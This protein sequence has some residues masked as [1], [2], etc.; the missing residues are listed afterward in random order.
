MAGIV[1]WKGCKFIAG[2]SLRKNP[3][4][5]ESCFAS[6]YDVLALKDGSSQNSEASA[7]DSLGV[8]PSVFS[9]SSRPKSIYKGKNKY[10]FVDE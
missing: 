7:S 4:H 10:L 2:F 1:G 8:D 6:E 5:W 3:R 9:S